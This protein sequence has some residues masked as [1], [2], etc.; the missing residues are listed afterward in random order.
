[1]TKI[2]QY[3]PYIL[4]VIMLGGCKADY[5]LK[6]ARHH[7]QKAE[8][9]GATWTRDTIYKQIE[10][11]RPEIRTDTIVKTKVGDT[12]RIEKDRLKVVYVRLPGDSVYIEGECAPDTVRIEVPVT[13][14]NEIKAPP[15]KVKW[16]QW[17]LIGIGVG[18]LVAAI[19]RATR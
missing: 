17:L 19:L 5:H 10:V 6:R 18:V 9:K 12:V 1:M 14:T 11:I 2:K 16:W 3:L 7:I 13:V 15:A 4:A 8:L